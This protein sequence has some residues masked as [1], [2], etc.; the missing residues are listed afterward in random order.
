MSKL[1]SR[2]DTMLVKPLV[3]DRRTLTKRRSWEST[4]L[5]LPSAL[6]PGYDIP[7]LERDSL[8]ANPLRLY[9]S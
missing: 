5:G 8:L 6:A 4:F 1:V 3:I 7:S 9:P 2:L